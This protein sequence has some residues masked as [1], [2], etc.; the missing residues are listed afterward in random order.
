MATLEQLLEETYDRL[1]PRT[2]KDWRIPLQREAILKYDMDGEEAMTHVT[3]RVLDTY[4]TYR[5][6]YNK[7]ETESLYL[8]LFSS[9]NEYASNQEEL[10]LQ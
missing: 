6:E 5:K 4:N 8:S 10:G 3:N 7:S 2:E 1:T 9:C